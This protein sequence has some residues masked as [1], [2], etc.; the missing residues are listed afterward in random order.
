VIAHEVAHSWT[1]NL[2]TNAKWPD[3]WLNE[4]FTV[5]T[6]MKV[7]Q[8]M[9]GFS[10]YI[11]S[12][13]LGKFKLDRT[14][15]SLGENHPFTALV[16]DLYQTSPEDAFTSVPYEK[17]FLFLK[18]LQ[19]TQSFNQFVR[20]FFS[21]S[22]VGEEFFWDFYR[23]YVSTFQYESISS[24]QFQN[25]FV[26]FVIRNHEEDGQSLIDQIDFHK[27]LYGTGYPS[28]YLDYDNQDVNIPIQL[29]KE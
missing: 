3:F 29:A 27:W 10:K 11:A 23:A 9:E 19:V 14:I 17:G 26:D 8:R 7:I 1:G 24:A 22:V 15:K 6:E 5:L 25:F 21:K 12:S 16:P 18:Y 2:I 20:V 4:A 13:Y 28:Y